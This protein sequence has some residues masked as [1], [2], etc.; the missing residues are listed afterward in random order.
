[1]K[2]DKYSDWFTI[3]EVKARTGMSE[4]AIHRATSEGK[5]VMRAAGRHRPKDVYD[6]R[7]VEEW[8]AEMAGAR[9]QVLP[10]ETSPGSALVRPPEGNEWAARLETWLGKAA[11]AIAESAEEEASMPDGILPPSELRHKLYLTE[12]EARSYTGL[13]IGYLR[14]HLDGKPIGPRGA[15]VYRRGALD[16]L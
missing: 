16:K 13:G 12:P 11:R 7:L 3:D 15:R 10:P 2:A 5:L 8:A 6:P 1:M 14:K 4:R 9:A